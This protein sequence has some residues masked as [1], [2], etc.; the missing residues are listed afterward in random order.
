MDQPG[1]VEDHGVLLPLHQAGA[2]VPAAQVADHDL[3]PGGQGLY[4]GGVFGGVHEHADGQIRLGLGEGL[5]AREPSGQGGQQP[6]TQPAQA[7]GHHH[8]G[9]A[10]FHFDL[11][12]PTCRRGRVS[13]QS[14]LVTIESEGEPALRDDAAV[15]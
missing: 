15:R 11:L 2:V 5:A 4:V 13:V 10:Q 3:G 14:A 1:G 8:S 6:L 7:S 9:R 12:P